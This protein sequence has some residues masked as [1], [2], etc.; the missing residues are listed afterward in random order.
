MPG[1]KPTSI[2]S[3]ERR[4]GPRRRFR[5]PTGVLLRGTG[6]DDGWSCQATLLNLS[7]GGLACRV[8]D[9]DSERAGP[10]RIGQ[11]VRAVFRPSASTP[12]FDLNGRIVNITQ[13][14]TPNLLVLG[15]EFVADRSLEASRA[16]LHD[17]LYMN[18]Q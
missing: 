11:T 6:V 9:S 10:L 7:I 3:A 16:G 1:F 5:Q 8:P 13:G 17:V 15:L 2:V 18:D 14:G 4:R 12:T